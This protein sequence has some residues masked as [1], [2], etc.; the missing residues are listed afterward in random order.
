MTT[1]ECVA[2]IAEIEANPKSL[3]KKGSYPKYT[4]SARR[5]IESLRW[6]IYNNSRAA[7]IE[8]GEDTSA[9]D[10]GYSGRNCNRS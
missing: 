5:R 9:M 2:K 4:Y 10:C 1:P 6:T 3:N 7:M 8:R